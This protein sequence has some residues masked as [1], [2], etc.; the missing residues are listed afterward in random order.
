MQTKKAVLIAMIKQCDNNLE[1]LN[2][3]KRLAATTKCDGD[4]LAVN[5]RL[6]QIDDRINKVN[7]LKADLLGDLKEV[8]SGNLN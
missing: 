3:M 7:E 5:T 4:D 8:S 2:V 6:T 1:K